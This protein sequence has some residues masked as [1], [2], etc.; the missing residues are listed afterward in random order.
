MGEPVV[1]HVRDDQY[2]I[3]NSSIGL[4]IN[5]WAATDASVI[6]P[7]FNGF[8][9]TY[10][11]TVDWYWGHRIYIRITAANEHGIYMP[12]Y[13]YYF[14]VV[15]RTLNER[16]EAAILRIANRTDWNSL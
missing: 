7:I 13:N 8:S 9:I 4:Y 16:I 2:T 3:D 6:A 11:P 1:V 12:N 14:D 15:R 5:G 10:T